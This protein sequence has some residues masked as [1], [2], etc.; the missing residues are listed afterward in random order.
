LNEQ[1]RGTEREAEGY[2]ERMK[3]SDYEIQ[4]LRDDLNKVFLSF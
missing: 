4:R 1:L 3:D 2:R